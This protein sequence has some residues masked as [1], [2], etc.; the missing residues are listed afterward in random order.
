MKLIYRLAIRLSLVLLPLLALWSV[1][2]YY[3]MISEINDETDDALEDYSESLI[4]RM[5][6]TEQ[7]PDLGDGSNNSYSIVPVSESYAQTHPHIE[8]HDEDVYLPEKEETE[9]ARV[10]SVI[11]MDKNERYYEL[12]VMTPTFERDDLLNT[13]LIGVLVVYFG[14]LLS[15]L[16]VSL[17]VF[18]K[19]LSPFYDLLKWLDEYLPGHR[20]R[21]LDIKTDVLE[22]NKLNTAVSEAF[23]RSDELHERQKQFIGNVSHELQTPLAVMGNRMEWMMDQLDLNE[24]QMT[25]LYKLRQTLASAV[26]LNKTLL[27]LA[28]IEDKQYPDSRPID[29]VLLLEGLCEDFEEIYADRGIRCVKTFLPSFIVRMN[30]TLASVLLSNL[31][32]N[33]FTHTE[34]GGSINIMMTAHSLVFSNSGV[35]TLDG[36]RIF[37]RFYKG[38]GASDSSGLGLS[39]V[40]A[41][42]EMYDIRLTYDFSDS[43]HRFSLTW[44]D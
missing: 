43:I 8:Y 44:S 2:F 19:S 4:I 12:K 28:K 23:G 15:V 39:L 22:F 13:V 1:F 38:D 11:F 20:M 9:P 6:A 41:I 37:D 35:R 42:C 29:L 17:I 33:A 30:D 14:I 34:N 40:K 7:L 26:R 32:K 36:K 27:M 3:R 16:I 31:I 18:H 21:P 5:L 10:M 24:S 25:E